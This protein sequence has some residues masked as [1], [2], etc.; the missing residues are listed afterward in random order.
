MPN[1][2]SV[3]AGIQGT[4]EN[5]LRFLRE[6]INWTKGPDDE[7]FELILQIEGSRIY[8]LDGD[9]PLNIYDAYMNESRRHFATIEGDLEFRLIDSSIEQGEIYEIGIPIEAAWGPDRDY[10]SELAINYNLRIVLESE[11]EGM[12]FHGYGVFDKDGTDTYVEYD[13]SEWR[14]MKRYELFPDVD[15]SGEE[16]EEYEE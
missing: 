3:Y 1:W 8:F 15:F 9:K 14:L 7:P 13:L 16:E 6:G 12:W 4:Q 10:F 11:E 5:I 2:C